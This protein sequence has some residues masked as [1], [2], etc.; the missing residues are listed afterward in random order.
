MKTCIHVTLR[1]LLLCS[2]ILTFSA[3]NAEIKPINLPTAEDGN[4]SYQFNTETKL[5]MSVSDER[6]EVVAVTFMALPKEPNTPLYWAFGYDIRF[7]NGVVPTSIKVE[8]ERKKP[9]TQD[10]FDAKP[11]LNSGLWK[12]HSKPVLLNNEWFTAITAKDPWILQERITILYEDGSKS[13]LHQLAVITNPM[14]FKVL[15]TIIGK[16]IS[17]PSK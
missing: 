7:K 1:Y 10:V 13:V 4:V 14:R 16:S 15:E 6:A 8:D 17:E 11:S 2:L 5:P 12:A 9:I 3:A